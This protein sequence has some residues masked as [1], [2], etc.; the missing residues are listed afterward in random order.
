MIWYILIVYVWFELR[1]I[2]FSI[3]F[4]QTFVWIGKRIGFRGWGGLSFGKLF[5][6]ASWHDTN[7][8]SH[9]VADTCPSHSP[10]RTY[11][12]FPFIYFVLILTSKKSRIIFP[13]Q[14]SPSHFLYLNISP[15]SSRIAMSPP[16]FQHCKPS[17][18]V[19]ETKLQDLGTCCFNVVGDAWRF[20]G[21]VREECCKRR[22]QLWLLVS[23][24]S[25]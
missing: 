12:M 13:E 3:Y 1:W 20:V 19:T 16:T 11:P 14:L 21:V 18:V 2:C 25:H 7:N 24:R 9:H 17:F 6:R 22:A 8:R 23:W 10:T 15:P 4:Q 5:K